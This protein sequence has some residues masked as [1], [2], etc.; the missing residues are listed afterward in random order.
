MVV[1]FVEIAVGEKN[2]IYPEFRVNRRSDLMTKGGQF[3]AFF[4]PETKFWSTDDDALCELV[5]N[6]IDNKAN[7]MI[8][9]GEVVGKKAY[10]G[11]FTNNCWSTFKKYAKSLPDRYA[12]LDN[13]I[14]FANTP[15]DK[16][17][18]CTRKLPYDICEGET[19]AWDELMSTLYDPEERQKIEWAIGAII[20]GDSKRIQKFIVIYGAPGTGKSTVLDI[21]GDMFEGYWE[22]FSAE[23]LGDNHKS[24]AMEPFKNNPR[25]AIDGDGDLSKI[26]TNT[27]LNMIVSHDA[28]NINEKFKSQY[29]SKITS[30]L[31]VGT[32]K[33]VRITDSKSGMLRRLIDVQPT[34]KKLPFRRYNQIKKQVAFEYGA[35]ADHCLKVYRE[36]GISYY[37]DYRPT[38]M[39]KNTND[40]F[41]F[42]SDNYDVYVDKDLVRGS[43]LWADFK[44]WADYN[45]VPQGFV[46]YSQFKSDVR[47]YFE[48]YNERLYLNGRNEY[49]IYSGLKKDLFGFENAVKDASEDKVAELPKW[50]KLKRNTGKNIFDVECA[51]CKAQLATSDGKPSMKWA[52]CSST[53]S[54]LDSSVCHY[55]QIDSETTHHIVID[56]DIHGKN[57]E[58]DL[59]LN[60][61]AAK[62]FPQTYA[63]TS[64]SGAGLHLHY[65]YDGDISELSRIYE[66]Q[67]EIK[68]FTGLSSLRRKLTLCNDIPIAHINSGLPLKEVGKKVVD[69]EV[70]KNEKAIRTIIKRN[71]NKEYWPNTKPSI[72]YIYDTLEK[73]YEAGADYDV[74][75]MR[76]AVQAFAAQSSNQSLACIKLVN[77]MHFRGKKYEDIMDG[78]EVPESRPEPSD[79]IPLVFFDVEV[80]PNLFVVCWKKRG[81]SECV[82]MIN[83]T[84]EM[85]RAL[86]KYR[87]I[88][89]NNRD[90]DN[91]IMYAR[92]MGY[93][94]EMLYTLSQRIISKD[95][96]ISKNAKFGEAYNLSYTDIY[97]FAA[98]HNKMGLKKWE[99]KLKIRHLENS[100]RWDQPVPEDKWNEIAEYCCNDVI[101]TEKLFEHLQGDFVARKILARLAGG[102]VNDTTNQL[103]TKLLVGDR[104]NPQSEYIYT[105]L[106]KE[107]PG[108]EYRDFGFTPEE[109]KP[110]TKIISGKSRYLGEDPGEGG[111]KIAY[112]GYYENVALLDVASMHPSS[113]IA[114][115]VF[116]DEITR[117]FK[118][119]VY[120]RVAVKHVRKLNDEAYNEAV[121]LLG[122]IIDEYFRD[123][124]AAGSDI[125]E[126]A[127]DLADALKTAINSVYGLTSA[128]FPNKLR[129]PRNKD[130]IVAKRGALFML[131]LKHKLLDMGVKI[132]HI[133]TDSI[134][135]ADATP[136]II[137]FVMNFGKQYGYTFEHEATYSKMCIVNDAVYIA[138]YASEESCQEMY[139]Y[140]P[141]KQK[142]GQWT[143]T[144][145]QFQVPYV[146]KT[147]FSHEDIEFDDLCETMSVTSSL[148][149]LDED[150]ARF[151]GRIG[152]FTPVSE[153]GYNL[154]RLASEDEKG[155]KK[156]AAATGSKG[157]YWQESEV[158][159]KN[160]PDDWREIVDISYY[161]KLVDDAVAAIEEYVPFDIFV[162]EE[163]KVAA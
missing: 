54:E 111:Y 35:I 22:P 123:G 130:N 132:A 59:A 25:I 103:T 75:D 76:P 124:L 148:Y 126:L 158:I 163:Q 152:E 72:D 12:Q 135:V 156:F 6:A 143:A 137:E 141:S 67:I 45:N 110:G 146:F 122:P 108:Y 20:S 80:F 16:R 29:R 92:A 46:R 8:S 161:R 53:L 105:D 155:N 66:D 34:G 149:L 86:F 118:N 3:Y 90:Y 9:R 26:S 99:I 117:R 28:L 91:H 131:T 30:F 65:I 100:H 115:N 43:E 153:G 61:E 40:I 106:A 94:N 101:S 21:V 73:A 14:I 87:L 116:G 95:K 147:L 47:E 125:R 63:E 1:D 56:F 71:L 7:D 32:N 162:E 49:S 127:S 62:S 157:H 31:F 69:Q 82:S 109:Y 51:D 39:I 81:E 33:P 83:P 138:K 113:A 10:L 70:I 4:N 78:T 57:G 98:A 159:R 96:V 27:R 19:P 11:K 48:E 119:I 55:V 36:M 5:D 139:G 52:D 38:R 154:M 44:I 140:L 74:T 18:Y 151:V 142:P 84:P 23:D 85:I 136:E 128:K 37:G 88:G 93:S 79:D 58:K 104:K 64:K 150:S 41:N 129:D 68:V 145:K 144:G 107:F 17:S 121:E 42:L 89:F 50:L 114:L 133:S 13:E 112:Y 77:K 24:F 97:D 120:G 102:I 160:H 15:I 134:K 2:R 60:L